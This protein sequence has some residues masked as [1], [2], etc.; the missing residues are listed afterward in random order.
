[1]ISS[2]T[3]FCS[4]RTA[5]P[6]VYFTAT[7]ELGAAIAREGWSLVYGGNSV[8]LME[9]IAQSAPDA[10]GKVIGITPQ[11]MYD[12]GLSDSKA[13]ELIITANMRDR[14]AMLEQRGDAFIALPG[15]LGTL[16]EISE[17]IVGRQ[18]GYHNKPIVLLN[19]ADYYRPM[20]EMIEHGIEQKFIMPRAW[21]LF[22][23][24]TTVEQAIAHLRQPVAPEQA[25]R[26]ISG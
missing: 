10:G 8:G 7:A 24:A 26:T 12:H 15:G 4:A 14:K 5:I 2:V 22:F 17:I 20:L 13:D 11:L 1:M 18:L 21:D 23:V 6:K 19:I 25:T 3:V 9:T 16:E